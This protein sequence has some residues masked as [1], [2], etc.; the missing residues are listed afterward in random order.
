[1]GLMAEERRVR[2]ARLGEELPGL[3]KPPF[4]GAL[5]QRIH[6]EV[7]KQAWAEWDQRVPDLMRQHSLSMADPQARKFLMEQ[8]TD[9]FFGSGSFEHRKREM[10]G[11]R[12]VQCAKIGRELP[13]LDKP[14]FKGALGQRI[15]DQVSKQAWELWEKQSVIVM[16]HYGIS[17]ADPEGRKFLLQ[18]MED[19]FFG[20]GARLPE[21]WIPPTAGG[22]KGKGAPA[23][24]RK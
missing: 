2:C 20:E 23:G 13:G 12:L 3:D 5:G 19:F 8:M 18:Q 6:D 15:Y 9:F 7:S 24:R 10:A 21:D 16:N 4:K 11:Q 22:G 17:L 1:M 14:P